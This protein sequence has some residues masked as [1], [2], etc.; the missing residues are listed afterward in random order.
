MSSDD[1]K[2]VVLDAARGLYARQGYVNTTIKGV[3]AAAGVAPDLIRRYYNSREELFAAALRF[4]TDPAR[5][6]S[7]MLAPGIDGLAERMVRVILHLLDDE[8]TRAQIAAM[9]RDGADAAK[10]LVSL[11]EFFEETIIDKVA[12][13]LRVPDARMRVTLAV[14]YI[15]GVAAARYVMRLE[16]LASASEDELVRLVAPAVQTALTGPR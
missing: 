10:A 13:V 11:R 2:R 9:A 16:P 7:Q 3:A 8:E 1:V 14:S 15:M 6:I 12:A 5:A 4:P